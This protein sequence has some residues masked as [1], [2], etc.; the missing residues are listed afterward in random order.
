MSRVAL[1]LAPI[2]LALSGCDQTPFSPATPP[3]A[4]SQATPQRIAPPAGSR[5][6]AAFD[7][8]S[9]AEKAA[10]LAAPA[11]GTPLGQVT[12]SLGNPSEQGFWLRSALVKE[13]RAGVVKLASGKTAQVDLL[14]LSGGGP[15]LS[16]A[17][18]R[19]LGL[20]L[21][22]LPRVTVLAR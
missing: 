19:A 3:P 9:A 18:Y 13:K 5:T 21:T 14:P 10:A 4:A 11:S 8:T 12:A 1:V 17:A 20:N 15:Q 22:D 6:A 7:R 2:T 16:L